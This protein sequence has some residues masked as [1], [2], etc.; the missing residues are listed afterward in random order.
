MSRNDGPQG[1][2]RFIDKVE[3]YQRGKGLVAAYRLRGDEEFLKDHFEGFPVMPGVLQVESARQAGA[4]FLAA[5]SD[6]TEPEY[7]LRSLEEAK[8]G[9]FVKPGSQLRVSVSLREKR[10]GTAVVDARIEIVPATSAERAVRT[11]TARM[12]L[13]PCALDETRKEPLR[14]AARSALGTAG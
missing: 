11:L 7:R 10:T 6:W 8:F 9:Q 12:E 14:R 2:F 1:I 5:E 3:D 4:L 13:E